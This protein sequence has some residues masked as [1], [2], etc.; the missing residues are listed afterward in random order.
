MCYIFYS[1]H[2]SVLANLQIAQ[3]QWK[4]VRLFLKKPPL[5]SL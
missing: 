5:A 4:N 3:E 1:L 2:G